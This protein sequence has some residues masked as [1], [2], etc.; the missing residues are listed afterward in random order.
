MWIPRTLSGHS[1]FGLWAIIEIIGPP[2]HH[3]PPLRQVLG[4]I[5]GSTNAV[6]FTVGKLTFDHIRTKSMPHSESCWRCS[7]TRAQWHEW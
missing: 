5:V 1:V 4:V 3:G 7:E 2:L 6:P